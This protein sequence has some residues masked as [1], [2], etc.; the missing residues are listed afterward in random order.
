MAAVVSY[1]NLV[2][3]GILSS[4]SSVVGYPV[5]NLQTRQLSQ[6]W[7]GN[8]AAHPKIT[9]DLGAE[10][11]MYILALLDINITPGASRVNALSAVEW[12]TTGLSWTAM[13]VSFADD[14]GNKNLPQSLV[15]RFP[16]ARSQPK[17]RLS[18]R[19]IRITPNWTTTDAFFEFGR[20]WIADAIEIQDGCDAGWKLIV[21]DPGSIDDSSGGQYYADPRDKGRQLLLPC[22]NLPTTVAYGFDDNDTTAEDVPSFDD[23]FMTV[24]NTG[25]VI[26]VHRT[27]TPI[28]YRRTAIYGHLTPDSL[29]M[30][31]EAGSY[32][33]VNL[34][35][36]EEH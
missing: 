11:E 26:A 28:W 8:K 21:I 30:S 5:T 6:V 17:G 23:L 7:R 27:D 19:Y 29:S 18:V 33:S 25:E 3:S 31:H 15:S 34:T 20:L 1:R 10:L 14:F 12:S 9:I 13:P 36:I 2:D 32:H 4:T 35:V 24:G 16:D 22:S